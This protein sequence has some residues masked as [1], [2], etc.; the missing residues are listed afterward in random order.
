MIKILIAITR[1]DVRNKEVIPIES[2]DLTSR[3]I[4]DVRK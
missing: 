2:R 4:R 3:H 1:R